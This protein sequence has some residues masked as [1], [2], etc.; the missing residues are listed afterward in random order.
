MRK[1]Y[2]T[3]YEQDFSGF[4]DDLL[5]VFQTSAVAL[6][7][8]AGDAYK[9]AN[10]YIS[11]A[12][13]WLAKGQN[14]VQSKYDETV[15][16]MDEAEANDKK[17]KEALA[18][19]PTGPEKLKLQAEY[20]D[21]SN[22]LNSYVRPLWTEFTKL[23]SK[24]TMGVL[25]AVLPLLGYSSVAMLVALS[26]YVVHV[27]VKQQRMLSDPELKKYVA[28]DQGVF[29]SIAQATANLKWPL[30]IGGVVGL[31]YYGNKFLG[32]K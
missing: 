9:T 12:N 2:P 4:W 3:N 25:P 17:L 22:I 13:D 27:I 5:N 7:N 30:L 14:Y 32:K 20:N 29:A 10:L 31:L 8:W 28:Q 18:K 11:E 24:P 16:K 6:K 1:I 26:A 23:I 21:A 19:M 15:K